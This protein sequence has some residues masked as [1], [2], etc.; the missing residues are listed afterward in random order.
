MN[1]R[2]SQHAKTEMA[3]RNIGDSELA[4][5]MSSTPGIPSRDGLVVRQSV[6]GSYLIR[7]VVNPTV[8]P[9]LV[10]TVYRTSKLKKYGAAP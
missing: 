7:A 9:E 2:T 5:V 3:R 8:D 10:V 6:V 4:A 1:Y